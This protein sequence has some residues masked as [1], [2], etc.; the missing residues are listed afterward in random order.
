MII[1]QAISNKGGFKNS[2]I[3][4][5]FTEYARVCFN[6]YGDRVKLWSTMYEPSVMA[7][8]SYGSDVYPPFENNLK[9]AL[10]AGH[11]MI[12][13]HYNTVKLYRTLNNKLVAKAHV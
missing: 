8:T 7:F 10:T 12:L 13:A 2:E 11:N 1:A 3:I 9:S 5:W 4:N 6:N